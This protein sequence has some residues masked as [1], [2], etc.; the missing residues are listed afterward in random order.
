[1]IV[2]TS[3]PTDIPLTELPS[4]KSSENHKSQHAQSSFDVSGNKSSSA[5]D[6]FQVEQ[7]PEGAASIGVSKTTGNLKTTK[8]SLIAFITCTAQFVDVAL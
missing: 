2:D 8:G 4:R 7:A 5:V 1:M 3:K 6:V